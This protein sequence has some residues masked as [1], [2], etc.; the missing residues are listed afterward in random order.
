MK[1]LHSRDAS[2]LTMIEK[3]QGIASSQKLSLNEITENIEAQLRGDSTSLVRNN[4]VVYVDM[5][6]AQGVC[7][8]LVY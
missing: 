1:S 5:G 3:L 7:V 8:W 4:S 6:I 2:V